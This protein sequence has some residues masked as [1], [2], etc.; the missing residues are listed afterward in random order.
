M[1]EI[2]KQANKEGLEL[3]EIMETAAEINAIGQTGILPTRLSEVITLCKA[4][5]ENPDLETKI[6][7]TNEWKTVTNITQELDAPISPPE[8]DSRRVEYSK[9]LETIIPISTQIIKKYQT[10][11]MF[12]NRHN[13][14]TKKYTAREIINLTLKIQRNP[15]TEEQLNQNFPNTPSSSYVTQMF[16]NYQNYAAAIKRVNKKRT[17]PAQYIENRL[18][19]GLSVR[20]IQTEVVTEYKSRQGIPKLFTKKSNNLYQYIVQKK[21]ILEAEIES[22][23]SA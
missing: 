18:Q 14:E 2:L 11:E 22:E 10:W 13:Y 15:L 5:K 7:Q 16:G 1:L 8:W 21:K 9:I 17:Q 23:I 4:R 3:H 12:W 6:V 19:E 20:Q